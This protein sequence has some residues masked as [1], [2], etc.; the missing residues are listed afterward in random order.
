MKL[1]GIIKDAF[2]FPSK[3]IGGFAIYL[4]LSALMAVFVSGGIL[5]YL[6]G[7]FDAQ[8]YLKGGMYVILA[9][10]MGCI[11]SGYQI[12]VIRSGINHEDKVPVFK[13]YE[14]F[15][16]GFD[17]NLILMFYAIIAGLI[18]LLVAF[19]TNL[20]GN[21]VS[22]LKETLMQI[23]NVFIMGDSA[24]LAVNAISHTI[25]IFVGSLAITITA[26]MILTVIFSIIESIA[27]ARLANTGSLR[28]ALSIIETI[29]DIRKIGI[30]K[31]ILLILLIIIIVTL[32]EFILVALLSYA[33][34]LLSVIY[35]IITPYIML[36]TLRAIGL[37]YSEV[38]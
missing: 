21:A 15:M 25:S 12:K 4:L 9:L 36:V 13:L 7:L 11:L 27:Q 35:I 6:L 18:V 3:N 5:T 33:P 14:D 34:F 31:V 19:D 20:F 2:R 22:I 28:E 23:F 24:N 30:I 17:S 37:L 8:N 1:V 38:A 32:I 10:I 16:T 26:A 29:K